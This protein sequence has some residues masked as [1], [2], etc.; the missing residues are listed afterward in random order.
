MHRTCLA[1]QPLALIHIR[2][3]W[4]PEIVFISVMRNH[5]LMV[6]LFKHLTRVLLNEKEVDVTSASS[7]RVINPC[8]ARQSPAI[9]EYL[10]PSVVQLPSRPLV[11]NAQASFRTILTQ[12][13]F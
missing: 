6:G 5:V 9:R 3:M 8:L 12:A 13:G 4:V 7:D 2:Q 1:Q 11:A 10:G